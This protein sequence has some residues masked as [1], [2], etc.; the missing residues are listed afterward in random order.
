MTRAQLA[1]G[2]MGSA[3]TVVALL[4]ALVAVF[5]DQPSAATLFRLS[6]LF[7]L[8]AVAMF[9]FAFRENIGAAAQNRDW[10]VEDDPAEGPIPRR[11]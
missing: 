2:M 4:F 1:V 11:K 9:L 6:G 3:I 8:A 10:L 7:L 5:A